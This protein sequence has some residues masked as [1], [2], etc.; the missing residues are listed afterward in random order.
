MSARMTAEELALETLR[1]LISTQGAAMVGATLA[2]L[3]GG[4]GMLIED[5]S[6]FVGEVLTAIIAQTSA[7]RVKAEVDAMFAAADA[8]VDAA[9]D[10]KFPPEPKTGR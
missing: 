3:T 7:E 1:W 4:P 10:A 8:I 5:V 6:I 9:E 2:A